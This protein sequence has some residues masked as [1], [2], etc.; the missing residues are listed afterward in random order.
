[1]GPAAQPG[2]GP[3]PGAPTALEKIS[4]KENLPSL[5][6]S[7]A[8]G[9]Q[10]TVPVSFS[11]SQGIFNPSPN[12]ALIMGG[13]EGCSAPETRE[14]PKHNL[15]EQ[16]LWELQW[17][18]QDDD[19]PGLFR[20]STC[21]C[22][23]YNEFVRS[24]QCP[25]WELSVIAIP[26]TEAGRG[27][28]CFSMGLSSQLALHCRMDLV[29]V[30]N[31]LPAT[32]QMD[33]NHL[34]TR[35]LSRVQSPYPLCCMTDTIPNRCPFFAGHQGHCARGGSWRA[36]RVEVKD[37]S[38]GQSVHK[39]QCGF[40]PVPKLRRMRGCLSCRVQPLAL[41]LRVQT[42]VLS[43]Q[44][45]ACSAPF[46]W[47]RLLHG[48]RGADTHRRTPTPARCPSLRCWHQGFFLQVT[49]QQWCRRESLP[50]LRTVCAWAAQLQPG[51]WSNMDRD[52]SCN[53]EGA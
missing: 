1:M 37:R 15:R 33:L 3:R 17:C 47:R 18:Q 22:L 52:L 50:W 30:S 21:I 51:Q 32:L 19:M 25:S 45:G 6:T 20:A 39:T 24:W 7:T 26:P 46:R 5:Y 29:P 10:N 16:K 23:I 53:T 9:K 11:A 2:K 13:F 31:S 41:E 12:K 8:H 38:G 28:R 35:A 48:C 42:H 36:Q 34:W 4:C 27:D 43:S 14:N 49:E 44:I 40:P